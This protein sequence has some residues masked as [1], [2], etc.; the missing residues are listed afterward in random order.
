MEKAPSSLPIV[1]C[2]S[3]IFTGAHV[4]PYLARTFLPWPFYYLVPLSGLLK[5]FSWWYNKGPYAWQFRAWYKRG[6][7]RLYRLNVFLVR[8]SLLALL[9]KI[10]GALLTIQ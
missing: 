8:H 6:K 2:H 7:E 3:H 1:N 4:P 5:V 10:L 9:K